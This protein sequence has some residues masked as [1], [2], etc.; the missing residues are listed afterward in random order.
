M[1]R[2]APFVLWSFIPTQSDMKGTVF[3]CCLVFS[4]YAGESAVNGQ[5][6]LFGCG[7][8]EGKGTTGVVDA[9]HGIDCSGVLE[10]ASKETAIPV[11][12]V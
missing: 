9:G 3:D 4:Y 5:R 7:S 6:R 10:G 8:G 12:V 2:S 1:N 11:G